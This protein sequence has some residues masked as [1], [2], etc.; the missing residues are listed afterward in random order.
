MKAKRSI[1]LLSGLLLIMF[2][3]AW[4]QTS[5]ESETKMA[6]CPASD[7]D[8]NRNWNGEPQVRY[9]RAVLNV[10]AKQWEADCKYLTHPAN[11]A[12][13]ANWYSANAVTNGRMWPAGN[14]YNAVPANANAMPANAVTN[15]PRRPRTNKKT[16]N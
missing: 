16:D 13:P 7:Y 10:N 11:A 4:A 14:A 2:V 5:I 15:A 12:A 8:L 6:T 3:A 1:A 9:M